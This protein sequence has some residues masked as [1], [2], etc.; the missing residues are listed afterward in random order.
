M[1]LREV[2]D[3]EDRL[4][5]LPRHGDL[6]EESACAAAQL[7]DVDPPVAVAVGVSDGVSS[8]LGDP[9]EQ[10]LG[11]ERASDGRIGTQAVTGYS[12]HRPRCN[13][14][15]G[16]L[17]R[18]DDGDEVSVC[19]KVALASGFFVGSLVRRV[20]PQAGQPRD[21]YMRSGR[22]GRAS[23]RLRGRG[24]FS[25]RGD[26]TAR[27][28][29]PRRAERRRPS[30]A[31]RTPDRRRPAAHAGAGARAGAAEGRGRRGREAQAHRVEP[32]ARDVD[33]A[34]LHARRRPAARPHPGRESRPHP[35]GREVRL[36]ARLQA[37][38]VCDL[39]DQAGDL[40][41]A[42]GAGEDDPAP[43][44]RRR[45]GPEGDEDAPPARPEAESR[46]VDRR[47]RGS[48]SGSPPSASRSFSTSFRTR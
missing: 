33:H 19:S 18:V 20:I 13:S 9:G 36:Q 47:D 23:L 8:A 26:R 31:L 30:E 25:H 27:A 46:P 39:V 40:A 42:R 6:V 34:E 7:R 41:G 12:A 45:P 28:A 2:A 15:I 4:R 17:L 48:R 43:G 3:V 10:R 16:R 37:L 32:A 1:A 29:G 5:G 38:D 21:R 35:R 14:S 24:D 22:C 44:P 11:R